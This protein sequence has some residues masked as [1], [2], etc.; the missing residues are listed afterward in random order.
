MAN[1]NKITYAL[2]IFVLLFIGVSRAQLTDSGIGEKK[3]IYFKNN[4]FLV[5]VAATKQ[6]QEKGLMFVRSLPTN[7]GM[8]F[9]YA[10]ETP[11]SFYMKN[12]YI[13]LDL[14][15]MDREKKVVFI[16]KDAK[17]ATLDG[18]ET[19]CPQEEA[20]YVLELNA[21]SSDRIGLRIG[22]KLQF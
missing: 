16:K 19:I 12:T 22:D 9:V 5:E 11:R 4:S 10:D 20:M 17:P 1:F 15:W 21:G 8:L 2:I 14:I 7:S 6:Q 13:P 18:Y 3:F